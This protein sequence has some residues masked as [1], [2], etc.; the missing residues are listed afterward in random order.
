M[1]P[2]YISLVFVSY[3]VTMCFMTGQLT[4][5]QHH[6]HQLFRT[7]FARKIAQHI[8]DNFLES[9]KIASSWK[10]YFNGSQLAKMKKSIRDMSLP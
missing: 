1:W 3:Y 7:D 8:A 2:N 5:E 10:G 6:H 9:D 4:I